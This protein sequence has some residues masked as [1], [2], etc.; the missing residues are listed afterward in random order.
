MLGRHLRG[1]LYRFKLLWVIPVTIVYA[2]MRFNRKGS[3]YILCKQHIGD[4][5]LGLGFLRDYGKKQGYDHLTV[6]ARPGYTD[7]FRAYGNQYD[8]LEILSDRWWKW[9][10]MTFLTEFGFRALNYFKHFEYIDPNLYFRSS[11]A[12]LIPLPGVT[13]KDIFRSCIYQLP[14]HTPVVQPCYDFDEISGLEKIYGVN[15]ERTIVLS[16]FAKSVGQTAPDIFQKLGQE[17]I[18]CGYEI[19]INRSAEDPKGVFPFPEI[20]CSL[21][22]ALSFFRHCKCLVGYRSGLMDCA[23]FCGCTII[24]VYPNQEAGP[25]FH[26]LAAMWDFPESS[27]LKRFVLGG[28]SSKDLACLLKMVLNEE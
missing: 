10:E 18:K 28:N 6:L 19:L 9:F 5:M 26:D 1:L 12:F 8:D 16:P 2:W 24:A 22:E 23:V 4:I 17:L 11:A 7:L 27:C 14:P 15:P 20:T 25:E 13:L 21:M 3:H